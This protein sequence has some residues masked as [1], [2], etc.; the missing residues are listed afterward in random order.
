[1]IYKNNFNGNANSKINERNE[2]AFKV[3]LKEYITIS[4]ITLKKPK[5]QMKLKWGENSLFILLLECYNTYI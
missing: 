2:I 3:Y 5:W 4:M 1:M